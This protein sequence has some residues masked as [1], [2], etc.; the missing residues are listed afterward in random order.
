MRGPQYSWNAHGGYFL[1]DARPNDGPGQRIA[2]ARQLAEKL[3]EIEHASGREQVSVLDDI[4]L[5]I[6]DTAAPT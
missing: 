3:A 6:V 1:N 5:D 2:S 4:V